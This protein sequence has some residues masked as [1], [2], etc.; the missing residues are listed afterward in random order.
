MLKFKSDLKT[1]FLS[2]TPALVCLICL[3]LILATLTAYWQVRKNEFINLDDD[4]YVTGNPS[5]QKGLTFRGALWAFTRIHSGHWHPVTW[6]SHM[7]D[8]ELYGMDPGGHHMTN[9][10]FHIANTLL[11]FILLQRL[12]GAL[13]RSGFVAALFALHPLHVESV[14]WV[15]ERKD[16]LCTFFW[17]LTI[18]AYTYYVQ[19]TKAIRYLWVVLCF[20][21]ALMSKPIAVTLPFVLLLLDYWPLGRIKFEKISNSTSVDYQKVSTVH[22]ILEKI[23]LLSLAAMLSLFTILTHLKSGAIAS[24]V[25]LPLSIRIE[26]ALVSY[27]RYIG[28]MIWP[29]RLAVLY[30]H[31]MYLPLWEVVGAILLLTIITALVV[32]LIRTYPYLVVGWLWYLGTLLPVIGL[33]QAGVQAMA[34][35]FTY[36]PL[37]GLFMMVAYGLPGSLARRHDR[38]MIL[39]PS[40]ILLLLILMRITMSQVRLWQNSVTLF[41]HTLNVTVNNFLIHNNLGVTLMR[42]GKDQEAMIHYRKA[43][44]IKPNYADAYYNMGSVL[45]RQ[46]KD[47]EALAH[48]LQALWLKPEKAETHNELGFILTKQGKLEEAIAH[49]AQ[50]VHINPNDEEARYNLGTVLLRRGRAQEAII[51]FNRALQINPKDTRVHINLGLALAAQ[52]KIEEALAHHQQAIQISP[53]NPDAYYNLATLLAEQGRDQEALSHFNQTLRLNPGD[54]QAHY[55]MGVILFRH[56]KNEEAMAHLAEAI[57]ISPNDGEAHHALG[58]VYLRI[59]KKDSALA[60]YKILKRININLADNLYQK[61]AGHLK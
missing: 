55:Q 40:G 38:R 52:G 59:G 32:I 34:D 56:G 15:A 42:Q 54:V 61:I 12:T 20:V 28:K 17:I 19:K 21:L 6:L 46:G 8:D 58:L 27:V 53:E 26:N 11:L 41:S 44:E 49:F 43:L 50:A 48:F 47:Q 13:W 5:V 7:L 25:K 37:I 9:L 2:R 57:R 14:A 10:F 4:L 45:M 39:I 24:F 3:F 51:H 33:V 22:L 31:P 18:F 1:N 16:V 30:P 35:R 36:I 23:P 60:E 29:D